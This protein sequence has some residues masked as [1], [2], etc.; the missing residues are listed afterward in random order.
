[1]K[2]GLQTTVSF[3][4]KNTGS[5]DGAEIAEVYA[6]L[7]G[8]LGEPP[9]RL[10]GFSK[11]SLKAGESKQVSVAINPKYL[12][13]FDENQNNWKQVTGM[14]SFLVGGSSDKMPLK[15]SISLP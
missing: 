8:D 10:V 7:P 1:V 9:K 14:Y 13:I 4:V 2:K 6:V 11:V 15:A 5:R 12:S 3:L